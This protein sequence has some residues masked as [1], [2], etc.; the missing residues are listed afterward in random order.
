MK[1][2]ALLV[3]LALMFGSTIAA[4]ASAE[5]TKL[6]MV[7][8]GDEARRAAYQEMADIFHELHPDISIEVEMSTTTAEHHNSM[9]VQILGGV[10]P[11]MYMLNPQNSQK[12]MQ[13]GL[14]KPLDNY[15][16]NSN[17]RLDDYFPAAWAYTKFQGSVYGVP[18]SAGKP[19]AETGM[20][21]NINMLETAGLAEPKPG[22]T[23]KTMCDMSRKLTADTDG[24]GKADVWG[25]A[26]G[27]HTW[28][29][30]W[31]W[32]GGGS[33]VNET[34]TEVTID[35]PESIL[36]LQTIADMISAGYMG[37]GMGNL[38]FLT[39]SKLAMVPAI[40][41]TG[42]TMENAGLAWSMVPMPGLEPGMGTSRAGNMI[43]VINA[44]SPH[45]DAAWEFLNWFISEE[46]AR[47]TYRT[48]KDFPTHRRVGMEVIA[49]WDQ[50]Y[51]IRAFLEAR[52]QPL[53]VFPEWDTADK[54]IQSVLPSIWQGAVSA[55]QGIA[56]VADQ[57]RDLLKSSQ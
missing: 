48:T 37:Y 22:W 11:D 44:Y 13:A 55:R 16:R 28:W 27:N 32:S 46:G 51:D 35:S 53:P 24:D 7:L 20:L 34:A 21:Y 39:S 43:L 45:A 6:R 23:W 42:K 30:N 25:V 17:V 5:V 14:V 52:W 4:S 8:W 18:H 41:S 26:T 33:V 47:H 2:V 1:R 31:L 56:S 9:I 10:G 36:A 19:Y 40:D 29:W 15:I 54:L 57:V 49:N 38:N 12:Y 50:P 3:V